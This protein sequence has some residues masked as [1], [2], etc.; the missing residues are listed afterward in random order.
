MNWVPNYVFHIMRAKSADT[1]GGRNFEATI[2]PDGL[3]D[4]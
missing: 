4:C 2:L 3:S 1:A